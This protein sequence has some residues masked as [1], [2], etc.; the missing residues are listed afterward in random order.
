MARPEPLTGIWTKPQGSLLLRRLLTFEGA[1]LIMG[2]LI[3]LE[4]IC[5]LLTE[6]VILWAKVRFYKN[7]IIPNARP[8]GPLTMQVSD[9]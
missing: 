8:L 7:K 3:T 1:P 2:S 9:V 6:P 4:E 5:H